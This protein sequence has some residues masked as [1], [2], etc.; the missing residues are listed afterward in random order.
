MARCRLQ[1]QRPTLSSTRTPDQ[2]SSPRTSGGTAEEVLQS[3]LLELARGVHVLKPLSVR[4]LEECLSGLD[5]LLARVGAGLLVLD[6]A[7]SLVRKE[8]DMCSRRGAVQRTSLLLSQ[9]A[10][11][12]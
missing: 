3:H 4:G 8:W 7:A 9:A 6:S 12:K 1:S 5:E 11:L 2:I 10:R